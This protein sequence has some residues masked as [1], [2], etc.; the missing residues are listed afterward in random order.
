MHWIETERTFLKNLFYLIEKNV[1]SSFILCTR[2]KLNF[3]KEKK[4]SFLFSL[5]RST[6]SPHGRWCDV[7]S[8]EHI[9]HMEVDFFQK[10]VLPILP[11]TKKAY[12]KP[13]AT[14]LVTLS[15]RGSMPENLYF[16]NP[17]ERVLNLT[18]WYQS[19]H[20]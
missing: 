7:N 19:G 3:Q 8:M 5:S 4:V 2:I 12:I 15:F 1:S 9:R 11:P 14:E 16:S 17:K 10:N 20:A 6:Y 18:T 13:R